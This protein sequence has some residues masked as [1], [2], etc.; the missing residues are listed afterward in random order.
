ML[1]QVDNYHLLC[2]LHE[3][4]TTDFWMYFVVI[5][6]FAY[7]IDIQFWKIKCQLFSWILLDI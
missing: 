3:A 6:L 4:Y 2:I 7:I 1:Y 5:S